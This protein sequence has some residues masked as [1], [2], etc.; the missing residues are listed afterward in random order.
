[1]T[2]SPGPQPPMPLFRDSFAFAEWILGRLQQ[3]PKP[4]ARALCGHAIQ[5]HEILT[6]ALKDRY[7]DERID[8]ADELLVRIRLELR[9]AARVGVLQE[10]QAQFALGE[11]DR[12]GRQLGGWQR[13]LAL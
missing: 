10:A 5:L 13:S 6:L 12:M 1:M 9:L 8:E 2:R 11:A 3:D 4:L 7:R